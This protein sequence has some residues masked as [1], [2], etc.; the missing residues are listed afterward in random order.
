MEVGMLTSSL[1]ATETRV[2]RSR[3][4]EPI[5]AAKQTGKAE[6]PEMI[7]DPRLPFKVAKKLFEGPTGSLSAGRAKAAEINKQY[8][9]RRLRIPTEAEL[10]ELN[11]TLGAQLEGRIFL[12]IW[13]ETEH[14]KN[15]GHFVLRRH[16]DHGRS[17]SRP[18]VGGLECAVR[19]V[20]D[21]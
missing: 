21:R 15:P 1:I 11:K 12:W 8:P 2:D 16:F 20:E 3:Q 18:G 17:Y 10:L 9:G 13:T 5:D 14:E 7:D 19:F 6:L 4:E